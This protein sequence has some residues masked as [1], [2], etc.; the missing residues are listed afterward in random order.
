M[1]Q[2]WI[3]ASGNSYEPRRP[4]LLPSGYC[5]ATSISSRSWDKLWQAFHCGGIRDSL[6][7]NRTIMKKEPK[8]SMWESSRSWHGCTFC[9]GKGKDWPQLSQRGITMA[10]MVSLGEAFFP[11]RPSCAKSKVSAKPRRQHAPGANRGVCVC[12]LWLSWKSCIGRCFI[13]SFRWFQPW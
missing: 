10:S 5:S 4:V 7:S 8:K 11:S 13:P 2:Y 9:Q 1:M 12:A 6:K 3:V